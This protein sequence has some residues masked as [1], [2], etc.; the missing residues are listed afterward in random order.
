MHTHTHT[1]T[2][3]MQMIFFKVIIACNSIENKSEKTD[4]WGRG[5]GGSIKSDCLHTD[6]IFY[7]PTLF[8]GKYGASKQKSPLRR[9][10]VLVIDVTLS[11]AT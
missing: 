2:I 5:G 8:I 7:L 1:H 3:I 11:T 10:V 9:I 4:R 6:T